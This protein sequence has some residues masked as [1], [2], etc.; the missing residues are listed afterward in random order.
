MN[1]EIILLVI[2]VLT[3]LEASANEPQCACSKFHYEEQMLEKMVRME[4]AVESM[5]NEMNDAKTSVT[6]TVEEFSRL[7]AEHEKTLKKNDSIRPAFTAGLSAH[8]TKLGHNQPIIFDNIV[9]NI[10]QAYSGTTGVFTA[11]KDGVYYFVA[12]ILSFSGQYVETEIVKNGESMVRLYSQ[13]KFHDQGTS[14]VVLQLIASDE[15]WVRNMR[16]NGENVHGSNWS[17]FS[18]F[19]I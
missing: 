8:L 2:A 18:G 5:K 3:S 12:T 10:G 11:P 7:K 14:G 19:Q 4:F 13:G 1:T 17:T 6:K 9:T 15:V 16:T